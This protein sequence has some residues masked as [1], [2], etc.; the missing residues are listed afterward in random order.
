MIV[1]NNEEIMVLVNILFQEVAVRC[2]VINFKT[3]LVT[4]KSNVL[5]T[6]PFNVLIAT[7]RVKNKMCALRNYHFYRIDVGE[8]EQ[9]SDR[10]NTISQIPDEEMV[11]CYTAIFN[12]KIFVISAETSKFVCF[13]HSDQTLEVLPLVISD[14]FDGERFL[15]LNQQLVCVGD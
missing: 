1:L 15:F 6:R 3:G 11:S 12:G 13:D 4:E 14:Y 2:L 9:D 5:D 8:Y 10:L 7:T